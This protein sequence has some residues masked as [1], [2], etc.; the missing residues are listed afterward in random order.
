MQYKSP[1][2]EGKHQW[3]P[4][5]V[6][7]KDWLLGYISGIK[8]FENIVLDSIEEQG[9]NINL[10]GIDL[11]LD[12]SRFNDILENGKRESICSK[13]EIQEYYKR[14]IEDKIDMVKDQHPDNEEGIFADCFLEVECVCGLGI[15]VFKEPD[16]IP[17]NQFKCRVCGRV[18]IDYTNHDDEEFDYDG[19]LVSRV[20]TIVDEIKSRYQKDLDEDDDDEYNEF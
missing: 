16:E 12:S 4:I 6:K 7:N 5:V 2:F 1:I 8:M 9:Y 11:C 15:Y 3:V 14:M 17:E 10:K 19:S 20:E 18:V 13:S